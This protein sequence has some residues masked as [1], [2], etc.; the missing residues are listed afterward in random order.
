MRDNESIDAWFHDFEIQ[1]EVNPLVVRNSLLYIAHCTCLFAGVVNPI[2][3][4][5]TF[6][7]IP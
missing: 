2:S 6:P 5:H 3:L 7:T 1:R 4:F